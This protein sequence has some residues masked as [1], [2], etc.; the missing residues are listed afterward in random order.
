[1][2]VTIIARD[3]N[4]VP[5]AEND[6]GSCTLYCPEL[7]VGNPGD[8]GSAVAMDLTSGPD[9]EKRNTYSL[10]IP[11][12]ANAPTGAFV[13]DVTLNDVHPGVESS[14]GAATITVIGGYITG[15][16]TEGV[17][18]LPAVGVTVRATSGGFYREDVTDENGIYTIDAT[19]GGGYTVAPVTNSYGNTI[20]AEYNLQSDW[21]SV[22]GTSD[23]PKYASV[24]LGGYLTA[25]GRV[26]PLAVTQATYD[27]NTHTYRAGSR[28]VCV[29]GTVLRQ[30]GDST[31][32]PNQKGYDGYYWLTDMLGGSDHD[33]QQAVKVK[34]FDHGAECERGDKI[35]VVGTFNPPANYTQGVVTPTS[36]PAVLSHNNPLPAPRDATSFTST[37]LYSNLIGGWYV[38][39][40]KTVTRV[41]VSEEFYVQVPD[42]PPTSEFRID[43]DSIA[44]TGVVYPTVGQTFD[45]YGI[46]D[47]MAPWNSLRAIR[48]GEP[49][50]AGLQGLVAGI[51]AA[52]TVSDNAD[53]GLLRAHVTAVAG[54][55]VP[56]GIA[57]IEEP[58]RTCGLRIHCSNLPADAGPGDLVSVQGEMA[59][60]AQGERYIEAAV[61]TR[62]T[63]DASVRPIDAIGM[64]NR[65]A[66]QSNALGLFI[67]TWGRVIERGAG[68]F[69]I[70]DGSPTP[71]KVFCGSL[72]RPNQDRVVRVRGIVSRDASGPILLMR[73]EQ[74]DWAY[75]EADY[76][77]LPFGGA[78]K[79]PRDF[80][81]LG[82][83]ADADSVPGDPLLA[84]TYRLDHDF[85]HDASKGDFDESTVSG[86]TS[87][88]G[89]LVGSYTWQRSQPAGDNASF[90]AIF[91]AG[92]TYCTFYAHLWVY[93]P[94]QQ[95][96]AI[97][98]GSDDSIK[99]FVNGVEVW[100]NIVYGGRPETQGQDLIPTVTLNEG[101]N[102]VLLKVEQ[103]TGAAAVDCQFVPISTP[104]VP[105]WGQ[106][107]PLTGL[108]YLLSVTQ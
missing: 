83:F 31:V 102:S 95:D 43:M 87:S 68:Y 99:V 94:I 8:P 23:W 37:A 97:R 20:P 92:N 63:L 38:L 100:R 105:G 62:T 82:P 52:K 13:V 2:V 69:T 66:S 25:S 16:V 61:F 15:T 40:N 53:V 26:W 14:H 107:T 1:M 67:K 65:D 21:P 72:T 108:G 44:T 106:A 9:D 49:G 48:P 104:G 75:G 45:I 46:L 28:T 36:A 76:Q 47:E 80:L 32:T 57:Y 55:G 59:T 30:A 101:F 84:Q 103:G 73:N 78:Y 19:P 74:V 29:M 71:I 98:V 34:V 4:S 3:E 89:R 88:R 54:G 60:T 10:T 90:T 41:G 6:I 64:S 81:V 93:S 79:Y 5:G 86:S 35:V 51:P 56:A 33:T 7:G 42:T 27:W 58:N 17:T 70:T 18:G 96:A 39:K 91:T 77:P 50:D 24:T 11:I 22:P 85:I 12:A